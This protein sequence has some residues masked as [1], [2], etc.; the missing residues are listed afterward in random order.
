LDYAYGPEGH[1]LF[2]FGVEG[3]TYTMVNG[4]PKYTDEIMNN[5]QKLPLVQAMGKHFRSNFNGPFL[6]DKRYIEQYAGLPEQQEAIKIWMQ[7]SNEKQLPQITPTQD[8]SKKFS[9]IMADVTTRYDEGFHKI[10]QGQLPIDAW[11]QVV[12]DLKQIG[13]DDAAKIQQ[14]ALE[15]YNKRP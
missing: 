14:A 9:T 3:L 5:P 2:N 4:Y 15:R 1:M 13:I 12:K 11:D 10:L 7:A 8:E 6:Q